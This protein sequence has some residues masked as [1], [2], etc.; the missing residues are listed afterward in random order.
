[1]KRGGLLAKHMGLSKV[2]LRAPLW[3]T[4]GTLGTHWELERNMLGTKGKK[5]DPPPPPPFSKLNRKKSRHF[6]CMLSLPIGSMEFLFPKLFIT[7]FGLD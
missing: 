3:N 2:L 5:K 1:V 7:I 4:L 6:E